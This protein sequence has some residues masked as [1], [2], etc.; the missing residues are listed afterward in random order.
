MHEGDAVPVGAGT[1]MLV[2]E[3]VAGAAAALQRRLQVADPEAD[4]VDAGAALGEEPADGALGVLA[5]EQLNVRLA[6]RNADDAGAV[7]GLGRMDAGP[8]NVAVEPDGLVEVAHGDTHVR[9]AGAG[10]HVGRCHGMILHRSIQAWQ[11]RARS[12]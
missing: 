4:V 9:D 5:G 2:E 11:G 1:R 12:R 8:E 10:Q 7:G 3:L 6:E